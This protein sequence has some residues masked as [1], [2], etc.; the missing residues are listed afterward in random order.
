MNK[1]M[2]CLTGL[3]AAVTVTATASPTPA[4]RRMAAYVES[5]RAH[6][7]ALLERMVRGMARYGCD[8]PRRASGGDASR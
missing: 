3:A 5:D 6:G 7:E 4:E 1:L 8:G 2:L